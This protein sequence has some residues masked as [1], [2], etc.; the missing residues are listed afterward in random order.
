MHYCLSLIACTLDH[1]NHAFT[2]HVVPHIIAD[3]EVEF[4]RL[5]R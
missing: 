3:F 4:V 2:P 5:R 1:K